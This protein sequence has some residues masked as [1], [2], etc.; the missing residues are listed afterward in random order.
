MTHAWFRLVTLIGIFVVTGCNA[1]DSGTRLGSQLD[2][3]DTIRFERDYMTVQITIPG[4]E[5]ASVGTYELI[6]TPR[7]G[8]A[9]TLVGERDGVLADVWI[10]DLGWDTTV[11]VIIWITSAG[12][13]SY[14]TLHVYA[15]CDGV[16]A[17]RELVFPA[18]DERQ[19]YMGHDTFRVR[20]GKLYWEYPIYLE[21]DPNA[22]PIGG[23]AKFVYS[24]DDDCWVED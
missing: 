22:A 23:T 6:I 8:A 14:G 3:G 16:Y 18:I 9:Q 4:D 11:E 10:Y 13:G 17:R 1:A 5:A 21:G 12:S 24:F 2:P 20:F 19:G 7:D 15:E